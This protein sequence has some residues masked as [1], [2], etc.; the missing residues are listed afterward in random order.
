MTWHKIGGNVLHAPLSN[1]GQWANKG[2][3][4]TLVKLR[5]IKNQNR[6]ANWWRKKSLI[7]L[8]T[9]SFV[10]IPSGL[11]SAVLVIIF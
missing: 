11:V 5:G 2:V 4:V 1:R 9:G 7:F 3:K 10:N 8:A 6:H